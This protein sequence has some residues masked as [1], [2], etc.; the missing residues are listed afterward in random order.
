MAPRGGGGSSSGGG[1]AGSS[2]SSSSSTSSGGKGS[3]SSGSGLSGGRGG[4]SSVSGPKGSGSSWSSSTGGRPRGS[5][6]KPKP[7]P[8][9]VYSGGPLYHTSA[10]IPSR[11]NPFS[12]FK[13]GP[14]RKPPAQSNNEKTS[15][16]SEA[17]KDLFQHFI[18][19][20][21]A[22]GHVQA[23]T[24]TT[25]FVN[26]QMPTSNPSV[27]GERTSQKTPITELLMGYIIILALLSLLLRVRSYLE[28]RAE[29]LPADDAD[30]SESESESESDN[31][32]LKFYLPE[33]KREESKSK[34]DD[35]LS[36]ED[37]D[38]I[39]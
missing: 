39:F 1:R 16:D 28:R 6:S 4:G 12:Y 5:G 18:Q 10:G 15:F 31:E 8:G 27:I 23:R 3:S 35:E 19:H 7:K 20:M 36:Q 34:S 24:T 32:D 11:F 25:V 38:V 21:P 22:Q 14:G 30:D 29:G 17:C 26:Q 33:E 37:F 13:L 2:S 9:S